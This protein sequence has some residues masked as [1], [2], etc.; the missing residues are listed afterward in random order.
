MREEND[1]KGEEKEKQEKGEEEETMILKSQC[2]WPFCAGAKSTSKSYQ[3]WNIV[4]KY[5]VLIK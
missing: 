2:P 3:Y 1:G 5:L 4:R